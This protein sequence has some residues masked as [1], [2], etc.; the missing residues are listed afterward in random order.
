MKCSKCDGCGRIANDEDETPWKF[1]ENLP[2][3]S[4][5]AVIAGVVCPVVCHV[6]NGTGETIPDD[7]ADNRMSDFQLKVLKDISSDAEAARIM[8][9][10][11]WSR[12]F[13]RLL[14]MAEDLLGAIARSGLDL[15]PCRICGEAVV[16]VPDGLPTCEQCAK[17]EASNG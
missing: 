4:G 16:C 8:A 7:D 3:K 17:M 2:L 6:C 5:A 10:S 12:I 9:D 14:K 11:E 13:G 15:S 1:W